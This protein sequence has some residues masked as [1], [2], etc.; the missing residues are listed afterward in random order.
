MIKEAQER[1]AERLRL[2]AGKQLE[3]ADITNHFK[4][5]NKDNVVEVQ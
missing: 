3:R 5:F 4:S 2:K 1:V